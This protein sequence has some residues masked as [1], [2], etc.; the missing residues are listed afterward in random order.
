MIR[1]VLTRTHPTVDGVFGR[2]LKWPSGEEEWQDNRPKVS[3]IPAGIYVC[4]RSV[5]RPGTDKALETFEVTGVP[6]RSLIKF[7]PFNTEEGTEGC[8]TL[9]KYLGVMRVEK[10]E[11]GGGP[12]HKLAVLDTRKGHEEFMTLFEGVD[13]WELDVR[14]YAA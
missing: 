3:C 14:N 6:G 7:H 5:W 2:F 10:P 11:E 1:H 13:R 9:G 12:V 4:V 8:I